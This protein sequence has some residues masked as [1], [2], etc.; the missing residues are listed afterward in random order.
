MSPNDADTIDKLVEDN[1]FHM[2]M[3]HARK[4][5][6]SQIM[7]PE[8]DQV[9]DRSTVELKTNDL[10][11]FGVITGDVILTYQVYIRGALTTAEAWKSD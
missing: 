7:K 4:G 2:Q 5:P 10:K 6:L 1:Y 8:F 3:K 11:A 9:S